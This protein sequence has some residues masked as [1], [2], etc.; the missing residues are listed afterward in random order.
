MTYILD[1]IRALVHEP[2]TL[3]NR[4]D[5]AEWLRAAEDEVAALQRL[6]S[7]EDLVR[8]ARD[9]HNA[10]EL[11]GCLDETNPYQDLER[12]LLQGLEEVRQLRNHTHDFYVPEDD[13]PSY[14]TVCGQSGDA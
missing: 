14:C 11:G 8:Q 3:E 10:A 13:G 5:L 7:V 1:R 4:R 9:A 12:E 6:T 2:R